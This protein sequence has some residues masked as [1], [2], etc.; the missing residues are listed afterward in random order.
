M[1][2]RGGRQGNAEALGF[3]PE[4]SPKSTTRSQIPSP[5]QFQADKDPSSKCRDL[6]MEPITPPQKR[7]A[8]GHTTSLCS[9]FTLSVFLAALRTKFPLLQSHPHSVSARSRRTAPLC[10]K[11]RQ[12]FAKRALLAR[13]SVYLC[14]PR[15]KRNLAVVAM[16]RVRYL[17]TSRL[18]FP[19]IQFK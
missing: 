19:S 18:G 9:L 16:N 11:R 13:S 15:W 3:H 8:H 17:L 6:L 14:S 2:G 5:W 7:P 10:S 1:C 4:A 12:P